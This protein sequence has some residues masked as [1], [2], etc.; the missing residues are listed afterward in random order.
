MLA[1]LDASKSFAS[2][3]MNLFNPCSAVETA[4]PNEGRFLEA[5]ST[6]EVQIP[7][8]AAEDERQVSPRTR[9]LRSASPCLD[10]LEKVIVPP[11]DGVRNRP[12]WMRE[13][14]KSFRRID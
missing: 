6:A 2:V 5:G 14:Q 1:F 8:V 4:L 11:E 7:P 9:R 12:R 10:E 13:F 3:V